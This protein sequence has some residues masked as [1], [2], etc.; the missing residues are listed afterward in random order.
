MVSNR[1]RPRRPS[2]RERAT[3]EAV[4]RA[5]ADPTRREILGMLRGSRRSVG[6]IAANFRMSRPAVSKHLNQLRDAGLVV[7][8]QEGVTRM[9]ELNAQPLR[10][11]RDWLREYEAFWNQSLQNLKAYVEENP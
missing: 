7:S 9:C 6:E 2:A 10:V 8:Q 11:V 3:Q 1:T 5:L 4:F